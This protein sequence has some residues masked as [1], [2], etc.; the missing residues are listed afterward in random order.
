MSTALDKTGITILI[1]SFHIYAL[2]HVLWVLTDKL[3]MSTA[4]NVF[5]GFIGKLMPF[6][7]P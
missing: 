2:K 7:I 3:S 5:H 1:V 4:I 6:F